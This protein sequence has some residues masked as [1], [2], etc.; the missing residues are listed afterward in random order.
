M[1]ELR[2]AGIAIGTDILVAGF[3]DIPLARYVSPQLT[4][5]HSDITRL[6]SIGAQMVLRIL[7][8][9]DL[10][11]VPGLTISPTLAVRESTGG[12]DS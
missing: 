11:E 4:T 9:E 5:V 8:G 12:R 2:D 10:G 1:A 3:D 6:G 7:D